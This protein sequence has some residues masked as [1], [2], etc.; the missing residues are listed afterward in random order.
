MQRDRRQA[1]YDYVKQVSD[2]QNFLTDKKLMGFWNTWGTFY[3]MP[4]GML[5]K[6]FMERAIIKKTVDKSRE[7]NKMSRV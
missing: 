3:K 2:S 7:Y 6:G 4:Y 1:G 5:Y